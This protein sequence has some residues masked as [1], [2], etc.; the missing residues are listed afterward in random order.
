MTALFELVLFKVTSISLFVPSHE[1]WVAVTV[2]LKV[3]VGDPPWHAAAS[4]FDVLP[5]SAP[6][7]ADQLQEPEE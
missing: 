4:T 5:M 3:V 6:S 7:W 1:P 2:G